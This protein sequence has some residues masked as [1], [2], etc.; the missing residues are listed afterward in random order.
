MSWTLLFFAFGFHVIIPDSGV[1]LL[2]TSH[3][4]YSSGLATRHL[5]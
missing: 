2:W 1:K 3:T 4:L 5:L